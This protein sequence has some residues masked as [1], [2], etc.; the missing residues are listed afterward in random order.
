MHFFNFN[1]KLSNIKKKINNKLTYK[2][3]E[4]HRNIK[5]NM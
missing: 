1:F 3:N 2:K 5:T 4:G